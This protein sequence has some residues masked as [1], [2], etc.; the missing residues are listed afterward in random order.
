M[1]LQQD[2]T[3]RQ[4]LDHGDAGNL[5]TKQSFHIWW[6]GLVAEATMQECVLLVDKD[7]KVG[8]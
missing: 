6:I 1:A 3:K 8:P 5:T 7:A 2:E 4:I